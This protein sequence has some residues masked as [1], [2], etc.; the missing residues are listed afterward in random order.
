MS[1][2]NNV[3]FMQSKTDWFVMNM[4]KQHIKDLKKLPM[5][6]EV[7]AAIARNE[8]AL[9]SFFEDIRGR[10]AQVA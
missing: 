6:E 7:I 10:S 3:V 4:V 5:N 2:T 9:R 8:A 1:N